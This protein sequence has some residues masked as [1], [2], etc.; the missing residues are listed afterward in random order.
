MDILGDIYQETKD[1]YEYDED[2]LDD[3]I[4]EVIADYLDEKDRL[5]IKKDGITGLYLISNMQK[6]KGK[7][8]KSYFFHYIDDNNPPIERSW[9]IT[10][11]YKMN[12]FSIIT[13]EGNYFGYVNEENWLR[14]TENWMKC[15]IITF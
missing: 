8:N 13:R 1:A 14:A 15:G 6:I 9:G 2:K 12:I 11:I 4:N 7:I 10:N 5:M 3:Y